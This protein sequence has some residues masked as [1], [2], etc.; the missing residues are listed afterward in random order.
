MAKKIAV[1]CANGIGDA[2]IMMIASHAYQEAGYHVTT[3]TKHLA[4]FGNWW[5][6]HHFH[7]PVAIENFEDVFSKYDTVILQHEN[8]LRAKKV[9]D[10]REKGAL[11]ELIVFYNNYRKEKHSS[12]LPSLDFAFDES[13]SMVENVSLAVQKLLH[14]PCS[15]KGIGLKVP[16]GLI[17]KKYP[18]QIVIHPTSSTPQ[19]NWL[20]HKFAK[21]ARRL[22]DSGYQPIFSVSVEER[23]HWLF[24]QEQ[25]AKIPLLT[26]LADLAS[27]LYEA[28]FFIGNDSGPGHLASYLN[29]PS[30]ILASVK[31]SISHWRPGWR[32]SKII[33]PPSWVPNF[34]GL[35]LRENHWQQF[36]TVNHVFKT[37]KSVV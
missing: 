19:K 21:L 5:S 14:L 23:P 12:L 32:E 13:I 17:F 26:S 35:R 34:K 15:P 11:K 22:S 20:P 6:N 37:F 24:L 10:L 33:L 7:P 16:E 28:G 9:F 30:I 25:G 8:S 2:L 29:I 36:I 18:K 1:V 4:S 3:F 27:L 31:H